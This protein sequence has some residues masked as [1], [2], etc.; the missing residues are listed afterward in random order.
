MPCRSD[1]NPKSGVA[2]AAHDAME[3]LV[4]VDDALRPE[5]DPRDA[6]AALEPRD[7]DEAPREPLALLLGEL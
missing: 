2:Q 7:R 5:S 3:E 1:R 4:F 6:E